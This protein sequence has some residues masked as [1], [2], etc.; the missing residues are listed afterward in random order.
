LPGEVVV[1]FCP[2]EKAESLYVCD[3]R[4]SNQEVERRKDVKRGKPKLLFE[5]SI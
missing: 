1:K 3:L 5:E 4:R 2:A